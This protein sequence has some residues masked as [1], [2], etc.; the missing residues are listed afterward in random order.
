MGGRRVKMTAKTDMERLG[1]FSELGYTTIKDPYASAYPS[2]STA[3]NHEG[4]K[5]ITKGYCNVFFLN[6]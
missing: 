2:K 1:I 5:G 6:G 3:L 4:L